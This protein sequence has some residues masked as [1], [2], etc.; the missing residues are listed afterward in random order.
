MPEQYLKIKESL[1]KSGK[2]KK[3]AERIAAATYNKN[4]PQGATPMG[5]HYEQRAAK[6]RVGVKKSK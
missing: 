6:K 1:L 5:P 3:E 4:R 2:G